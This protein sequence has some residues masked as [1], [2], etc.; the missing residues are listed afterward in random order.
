VLQ[1]LV[2]EGEWVRRGQL[3]AELDDWQVEHD[4]GLM[5]KQLEKAQHELDLLL[6]GPR[7]EQVTYAREQV[8]MAKVKASH[9]GKLMDVLRP[10]LSRGSVSAI[11]YAKAEADADVDD[12]AVTVAEANLALT[13]SGPLELEIAIK[14]AEVDR[15]QR[16]LDYLRSA[17]ERTQ[18]HSP[19]EGRLATARLQQK[20]GNF[21]KEGDLFS[22]VEDTRVIQA[23]ILVPETDVGDVRV[24]ASVTLKV[25][26]Y[27]DNAFEGLVTSIAPVV[28][29]DPNSPFV[30]VVRVSTETS[31]ADGRLKS[32]MTGFAK[33]DAGDKPVAVAF[34]RALARFFAIEIWSWLP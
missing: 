27:P 32:Q 25:W 18:I 23:E 33:I 16:E 21:L 24:G 5:E 22:V 13:A 8:S 12:A 1:V 15:T 17:R 28:E 4:I 26:A 10:G 14:R 7:P 29:E 11:E 30:R 6:A 19:T 34:T 3:L 2:Q 31:N 20:I 9:S